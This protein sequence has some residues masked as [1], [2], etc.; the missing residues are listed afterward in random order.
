MKTN[1]SEIYHAL[2]CLY[3]PDCPLI[4]THLYPPGSGLH[5][6]KPDLP[7]LFTHQAFIFLGAGYD[8]EPMDN[9][10]SPHTNMPQ[11]NFILKIFVDAYSI[12]DT[13]PCFTFL[14]PVVLFTTKAPQSL[15]RHCIQRHLR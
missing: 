14:F 5:Q 1:K 6:G 13:R 11:N 8:S 10:S 12:I 15:L 7:S 4:P 2:N 3:L 9:R